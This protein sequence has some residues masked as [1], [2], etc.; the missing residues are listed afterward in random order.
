[1]PADLDLDQDHINEAAAFAARQLVA[2]GVA[3]IRLSP[4]DMTEYR[5]AIVAPG[6][7]FSRSYG[8]VKGR[9]FWVTLCAGFGAGYEW[10]GGPVDG[11]YAAEKWANAS[12]SK[13]T[14][15]HTGEVIARFLSAVFAAT[16]P[17]AEAAADNLARQT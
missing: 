17:A 10:H 16:R 15:A 4:G 8:E 9:Y 14:R 1:M 5:I 12:V 7:E 6:P 2:A 13:G 3:R 11:P